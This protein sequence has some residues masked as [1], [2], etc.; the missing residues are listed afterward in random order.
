MARMLRVRGVATALLAVL[1]LGPSNP[2]MPALA[3]GTTTPP[4]GPAQ[5]FEPT[6]ETPEVLPPGNG[7]DEAFYLCTGCHGTAI[8]TAQGMR[9]DQW[10]ET[11]SLMV[12]KHR[13]PA[14]DTATRDLVLDYLA[15]T[16]PARPAQQRGWVNPFLNRQSQ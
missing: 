3:Q 5:S 13:M 9:R 11:V 15:A 7:R 6:E 12:A 8:V 2:R 10:D 4:A 16:F 1:M 14:P